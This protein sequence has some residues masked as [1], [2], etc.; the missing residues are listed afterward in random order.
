MNT[1]KIMTC[2]GAAWLLAGCNPLMKASLDT[3]KAAVAGPAPLALS[4][5]Q[6]D[7]VPFPQIKVAT[8]SSEGTMALIR[9]RGDL[10][11][12]VASG[13]QVVLLRN[14]LVVRTVGLGADLDG[15]RWQGQSPFQQGLHQVPDGYR[16]TRQLDVVE[17]YRMGVTLTSRLTRKGIE[18]LQIL[19]KPYALLRV[20][21]DIE[22]PQFHARNRYWVDP[23]D[24][25]IVQSEQHLTPS[26][27]LTI[28][29]LQPSRKDAR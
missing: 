16:S 3:F 8:M 26:L 29:Q 4:Q 15:T 24:G 22:A 1:L 28:T 27:T 23:S 13:K 19:D 25:F 20:D 14:G 17:G 21:E 11:F 9:Q 10:Q 2:M 18:T 7:A 12:W 5:A 6:L